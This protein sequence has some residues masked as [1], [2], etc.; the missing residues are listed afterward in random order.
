VQLPLPS[1]IH[2]SFD[3][4]NFKLESGESELVKRKL[5]PIIKLKT[6]KRTVNVTPNE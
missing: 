5:T 4:A 3:N 2:G 6:K 1:E